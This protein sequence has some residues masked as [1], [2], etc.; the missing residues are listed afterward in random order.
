VEFLK[1]AAL[2]SKIN[3][4]GSPSSLEEYPHPFIFDSLFI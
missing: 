1:L 2:F 4:A 3:L